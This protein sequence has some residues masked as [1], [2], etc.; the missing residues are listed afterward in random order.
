MHLWKHPYAEVAEPTGVA[1]VATSYLREKANAEFRGLLPQNLAKPPPDRALPAAQS[2]VSLLSTRTCND[3]T[4]A[5][6]HKLLLPR[7]LASLCLLHHKT[8]LTWMLAIS[9]QLQTEHPRKLTPSCSLHEP[10]SLPRRR[11]KTPEHTHNPCL[12]INSP[13][14]T[15]HLLPP[16]HEDVARLW[17]PTVDGS[18]CTNATVLEASRL[19]SQQPQGNSMRALDHHG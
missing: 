19:D 10:A 6:A 12:R 1:E 5:T 18:L 11:T 15:R 9:P 13:H 3:T 2:S 8:G 14:I 17:M 4:C 16:D 7:L